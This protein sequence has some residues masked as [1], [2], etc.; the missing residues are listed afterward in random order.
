MHAR[1]ITNARLK[2]EIKPK[3]SI[4]Q[5]DKELLRISHEQ[6]IMNDILVFS[7]TLK[8]LQM[9]CELKLEKSV[10]AATQRDIESSARCESIIR[11]FAMV[12]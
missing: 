8:T 12:H 9:E 2:D 11:V 7:D 10:I 4:R 5:L 6:L 3:V 1:Q